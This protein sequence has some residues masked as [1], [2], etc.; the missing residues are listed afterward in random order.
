M[1]RD[2]EPAAAP[3]QQPQRNPHRVT[4]L[5]ECGDVLSITD[6]CQLL[7]ISRASYFNLKAHRSF[8]IPAM[9][10]LGGAVRYRKADVERYLQ[11]A[12]GPRHVKRIA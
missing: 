12:S 6:L 1:K 3:L 5:S 2:L 7:G 9:E 10:G 4:R 8:P 11:S